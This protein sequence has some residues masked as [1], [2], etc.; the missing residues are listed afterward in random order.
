MK[1]RALNLE[2][3]LVT[4]R[5]LSLG[6]NIEY[7]VEKAVKGGTSL[8]QLREKDLPAREFIALGEKLL[9][10]LSPRGIPLL[11]ND[12]VDIA[13]AIGADG[14]HIGQSDIPYPVARKILGP[15][16]IIGLSVETISQAEEANRYDLNYIAASPVFTT[17]TKK[18][19]IN[20]LGLEG[21]SKIRAVSR[22]PMVAIGGIKS[23]NAADVIRAGADGVAIVS[24][25]CSAE[26]PEK[27]SDEL[28]K[29]VNSVIN[30]IR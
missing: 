9:H 14:V 3:Y 21:V 22:H 7:I 30:K 15:R 23:I 2:L 20:E 8:V 6:R 26:D 11:I 5:E 27:A 17:P 29:I 25:I 18:E 16:A 19:L 1:K 4:D 12:R 24:G 10:I 13:L 28:K